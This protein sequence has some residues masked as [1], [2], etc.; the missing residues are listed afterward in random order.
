MNSTDLKDAAVTV[1]LVAIGVFVYFTVITMYN[2]H[3]SV[4]SGGK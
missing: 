1:L 3:K 4:K 2:K